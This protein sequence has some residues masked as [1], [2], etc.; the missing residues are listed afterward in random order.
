MI[1]PGAW[2]PR[3]PAH[4]GHIVPEQQPT[5]GLGTSTYGGTRGVLVG[6]AVG[7]AVGVE[8]G[9]RVGIEAATGIVAGILLVEK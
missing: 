9:V 6:V 1:T 2:V 7:V 3:P 8:V 5:G 4:C